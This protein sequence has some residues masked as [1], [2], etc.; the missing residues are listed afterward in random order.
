MRNK[1]VRDAA[2]LHIANHCDNSQET[3]WI[4][5][6]LLELCLT[7]D[8]ASECVSEAVKTGLEGVEN[9]IKQ[10]PGAG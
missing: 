3:R 9:E 6:A 2:R 8:D 7:I 10:M 4:V 1:K 5:E